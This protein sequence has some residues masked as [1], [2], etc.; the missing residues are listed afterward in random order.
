MKQELKDALAEVKN[1][2][3]DEPK[4]YDLL[5]AEPVKKSKVVKNVLKRVDLN[6]NDFSALEI[7]DFYHAIDKKITDKKDADGNFK[8]T[9]N[10]E[11]FNLPNFEEAEALFDLLLQLNKNNQQQDTFQKRLMDGEEVGDK[12][13]ENSIKELTTILKNLDELTW[14][15]SG[16]KK[17]DLT[18]WE[19]SLIS[20]QIIATVTE[21]EKTSMGK[22]SKS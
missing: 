18:E 15:I 16:L 3:I 1:T 21:I 19:Q 4:L 9:K 17:E 8:S 5:T 11:S 20:E 6:I 13:L 12:E 10:T 7:A 14:Q 2:P 22:Q